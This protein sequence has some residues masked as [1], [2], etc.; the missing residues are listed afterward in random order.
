MA[1]RFWVGNSG[2]ISDNTNHWSA[3]SGGS[4]NATT[5][6]LADNVFFDINSFSIDAQV[7]TVD[8]TFACLS[9]NWTGATNTPTFAGTNA[10]SI[11]GSLVFIIPM[12]VTYSSIITFRSTTIGNTIT[13]AG[14]T[15]QSNITFSGVGGVW[16]LQDN[17]K[18]VSGKNFN[19][20]S[21]TFNSGNKNLDV[22][23]M[24]STGTATRVINFG[25]STILCNRDWTLS[26]SGY[27]LDA[28]E[29]S[30]KLYGSGR[31]FIGASETYK[32]LWLAGNATISGSNNFTNLKFLCKTVILTISTTQTVTAK[33]TTSACSINSS[34]SGTPATLSIPNTATVSASTIKDITLSGTG[35]IIAYNSKN[36][37]G[38]SG[39][40]NFIKCDNN[41][42]IT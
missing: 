18:I 27:T 7:V 25:T 26:G 41:I 20:T 35:K 39:N 36:I 19:V 23:F 4:P 9:M 6:T 30:F 37:S 13:T 24:A 14:Q 16:T 15:I 22:S 11:Y 31:L 38:N 28:T 3:T 21:G 5:P 34:A 40:I 8:A 32:E 33:F 1:N 10:V 2:N 17:L 29:A 42:Y 12:I